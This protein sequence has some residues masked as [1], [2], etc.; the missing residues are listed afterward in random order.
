MKTRR[1]HAPWIQI[2]LTAAIS[3]TSAATAAVFPL[4]VSDNRRYLVGQ[5]N[6]PFLIQGCAGWGLVANIS[7]PD[8]ELYLENRRVKGFNAVIVRLIDSKFQGTTYT[9]LPIVPPNNWYGDPPF[10]IPNDFSTPNDSYF[11]HAE[12]VMQRA[13]EK[14]IV[15]FLSPL[16]LGCKNTDQ[17][18]YDQVLASGPQQC[19]SY[20][21]Y[22]GRRFKDVKNIVWVMAGD[23]APG[24]AADE[25]DALMTGIQQFD[26]NH[27]VTAHS[28]GSSR[29][30]FEGKPWLNVNAVYTDRTSEKC[31]IEYNKQ[32]VMPIFLAESV[33][34]NEHGSTTAQI[35]RQAYWAVLSGASGQIFGNRPI[36]HFG[37]G[38]KAA[39]ESPA[40]LSLPH[41]KK[42]FESR[43]WHRL[44]PD[45][46]HSLAVAGYGDPASD[47]YVTTAQTDDGATTISYI[48]S[49]ATVRL[50]MSQLAGS[51][52]KAWWFDPRAG[53]AVLIGSYETTGSRDF[54]P[55][56]VDD[57]VLVLDDERRGF[58]P[59]GSRIVQPP[60]NLRVVEK[61]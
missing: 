61:N 17:G 16:Y 1:I 43:Q 52:A 51:R 25:I 5:N 45:F 22:L 7:K 28:S 12:W 41:L 9:G 54:S 48:P 2:V 13:A 44:T 38:W 60:S 46:A 10:T 50:N 56:S 18:W 29:V 35:R 27:L 49:G 14:G 47:A 58:D 55:P 37:S 53:T 42:L 24:E 15:L 21:Q 8:A 32:P 40:S 57:W 20:G 3:A 31:T 23:R 36:W 59:P 6:E 39:L 19:Q 4:K 26:T 30:Y 11:A 34:E 33:Y